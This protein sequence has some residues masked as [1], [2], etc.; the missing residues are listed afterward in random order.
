MLGYAPPKDPPVL[1]HHQLTPAT[2]ENPPPQARL[3]AHLPTSV[4]QSPKDHEAD[5][6]GAL[7]AKPA[8]PAEISIKQKIGKLGL[9]QPNTPYGH[10][11]DTIPLLECYAANACPILCAPLWSCATV[12]LL[13]VVEQ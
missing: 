3:V 7:S 4:L 6:V 11:H 12:T 13:V 10:S 5:V 1:C 9:M 2:L 8:V